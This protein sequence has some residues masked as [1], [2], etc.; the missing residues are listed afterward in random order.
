MIVPEKLKKGDLIG[1]VAPSNPII[2]NN[3][4]EIQAAKKIME[5]LGFKVRFATNLFANSNKYSASA[6]EKAQD[7]N[8]MFEDKN[9]KMIWCA[10]GGEN[11]NSTFEYLDF[12]LIKQNPKIICGYSDITALTN[13]I[14]QKTGLITYSSTNFK[15]IAT[16]ETDYSLKQVINR[17]VDGNL[18]LGEETDYKI[19]Q[20]G[21]VE[22]QLIG[23]NL[24]LT[25]ALTSGKYN[26]DFTD[27]ILFLEELGF[28]TCPSLAN[29]YLYYM[30]Q[31]DV[32]KKIK[33]IWLGNYTHESKI[34]LEQILLDV[35]GNE[36]DG[37]IIKSDNFGHIEK[38][39]VIPIGINAKIDT[40][41]KIPIELLE[42]CVK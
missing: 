19:I 32:F 3:I 11:S 23:G 13:I 12:D 16:D 36:F 4:E 1:V 38:K 21:N 7:I 20:K 29:N 14:T 42:K 25:R 22:G 30:K 39:I 6:R 26:I 27:K 34:T 8:E 28:E 35:I 10:K 18:R 15:T 17:F 41:K 5:N 33:G 9:V 31:N 2:D 37:P 24:S 40:S